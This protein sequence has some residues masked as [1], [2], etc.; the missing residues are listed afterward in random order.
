LRAKVDKVIAESVDL[1][2]ARHLHLSMGTSALLL[3]TSVVLASSPQHGTHEEQH[4]KVNQL[5]AKHFSLNCLA[6]LGAKLKLKCRKSSG[7]IHKAVEK[8]TAES[9]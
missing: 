3:Q 6:R 8:A 4:E 5:L 9:S 7:F 2:E 1:V